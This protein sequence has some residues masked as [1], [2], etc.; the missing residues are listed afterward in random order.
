[1]THH[2]QPTIE[3]QRHKRRSTIASS[4]SHRISPIGSISI[5][6]RGGDRSSSSPSS[7][8]SSSAVTE[9]LKNS[10]ASGLAAAC[11]KALLAPFDTIKT[12]QQ[13][14]R[15]SGE[16]LGFMDAVS[17]ICK[18]KGGIWELYSG[19]G[20]A[21]LG[22][23]PSVGLYFGVYSYSKR[24]LIPFFKTNY[25]SD[26]PDDKKPLFTDPTL[27]TLAIAL[28]ATIG[29]TVASFSR[30]P[31]EVVK[32]KLQ[33]GLHSS[34][35]DALSSMIREGGL[36]AFFPT[37]GVSIQMVRDIPY[38]VF[39]LLSYEYI[40]DNWV[41][42]VEHP[43]AW[44]DMAAGATAGGIGSYLTNPLD[45]IKTR[46]QTDTALYKGSI[47]QCAR[48]T[49]EEGGF[50]AFLRGSVPR[51]MHKIPANG[52]FFLFYE[53]FRRLLNVEETKK[54]HEKKGEK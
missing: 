54:S 30:V 39:T 43:S 15:G 18:R 1:M 44:R 35:I 33:S 31:F 50:R 47:T 34:T 38:A 40:R 25:G 3:R 13:K 27:R 23:M 46:I 9:G 4:T 49:F 10:L 51:L 19:L 36:R 26:R 14:Y 29:N 6:T 16:A 41:N 53:L 11:S 21:A 37:G 48:A 45:V 20:V 17:V 28:S 12:V 22:S 2:H 8:S 5:K 24:I 7:S 52:C 32:Q 42:K